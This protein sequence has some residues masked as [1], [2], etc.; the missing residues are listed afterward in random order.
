M[1]TTARSQMG[2]AQEPHFLRRLASLLDQEAIVVAAESVLVSII[3]QANPTQI[4]TPAPHGLASG[5]AVAFTDTNSTPALAGP[6]SVTVVDATR[7]TVPVNVTVAGTRGS[8]T[9]VKH[10]ARRQLAQAIITNPLGMATSLAPTICNATNL[11][12]ANTT[13]DFE[14]G[15]IITDA[16]DAAIRSQIATLWNLMAGA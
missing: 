6:Y 8:F 16:S 2:L 5:D 9:A 10:S 4:T 3:S 14:A 12:A 13:Y 7:F 1:P 11:I 15:A